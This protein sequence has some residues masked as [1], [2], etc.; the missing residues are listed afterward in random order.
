MQEYTN[1]SA[2]IKNM[3]EKVKTKNVKTSIL[4]EKENIMSNI[5]IPYAT[6]SKN[7]S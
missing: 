1:I 5:A 6:M 4:V 3:R 7:A 2:Q